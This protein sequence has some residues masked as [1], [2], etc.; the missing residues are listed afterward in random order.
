LSLRV[1]VAL[2]GHHGFGDANPIVNEA[3]KLP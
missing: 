1:R 3:P 2:L